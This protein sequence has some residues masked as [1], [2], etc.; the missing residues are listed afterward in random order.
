MVVDG[1]AVVEG[2]VAVIVAGQESEV[3]VAA[4]AVCMG[5]YE[6]SS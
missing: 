6:A 2:F 3:P 1:G 4:V 5:G